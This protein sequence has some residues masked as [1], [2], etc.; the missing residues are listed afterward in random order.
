M[1]ALSRMTADYKS[2]KNKND[3]NTPMKL[4]S[5]FRNAARK[6]KSNGLLILDD[7]CL[8]KSRERKMIKIN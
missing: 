2:R 3:I 7:W 5:S 4:A 8:Y 1:G 6:E